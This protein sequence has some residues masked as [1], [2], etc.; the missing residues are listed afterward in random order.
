[1]AFATLPYPSMDFV[2]LDILTADEL[3]Q[4]VANINAVNNGSVSASQLANNAVTTAK[5]ADSAVTTAKLASGAVTQAKVDWSS[6][7]PIPSKLLDPTNTSVTTTPTN[8]TSVDISNIPTGKEFILMAQGYFRSA[9][10]NAEIAIRLMY[11]NT[12]SNNYWFK[13]A[14]TQANTAILG[15]HKFTKV[16]SVNTAYIQFWTGTSTF[17][18]SDGRIYA[19]ALI[20]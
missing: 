6:F 17:T 19:V 5:I 12:A 14:G 1:M 2:P 9:T 16:A 11:N 3:D 18:I 15:I 7:D 10:N 4:I 20:S 8:V 13:Q